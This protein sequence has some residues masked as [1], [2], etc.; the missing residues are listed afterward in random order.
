MPMAVNGILSL[1]LRTRRLN[2]AR[3]HLLT[4]PAPRNPITSQWEGSYRISSTS[5]RLSSYFFFH[6]LASISLV[7]I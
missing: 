1:R 7:I 3:A 5:W 4:H 2:A 6:S